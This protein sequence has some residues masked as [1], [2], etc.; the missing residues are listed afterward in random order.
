[1]GTTKETER[2][3][4]ISGAYYGPT[5]K[6]SFSTGHVDTFHVDMLHTVN[7]DIFACIHFCGFMKMDNFA[8]IVQMTL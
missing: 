8:C 7:V 6:T 5:D 1:M 3:L 2:T 4:A